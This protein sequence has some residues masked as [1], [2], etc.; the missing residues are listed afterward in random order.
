[1]SGRKAVT[2]SVSAAAELIR[3]R[4]RELT[5]LLRT[6]VDKKGLTPE[7]RSLVFGGHLK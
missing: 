7:L 4:I 2:A 3:V 6:K 1:M 5:S